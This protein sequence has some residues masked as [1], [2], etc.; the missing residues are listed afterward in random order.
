MHRMLDAKTQHTK[1]PR[2][3]AAKLKKKGIPTSDD[4]ARA[5]L[6]ALRKGYRDEKPSRAE[7]KKA[8]GPLIAAAVVHLVAHSFDRKEATDRLARTIF[9]KN[10]NH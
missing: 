9:R 8:V 3:Y 2:E 5:M 6:A 4:L 1:G 10:A 7:A